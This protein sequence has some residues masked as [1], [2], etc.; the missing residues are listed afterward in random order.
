MLIASYREQHE[1]IT[2]IRFAGIFAS[3][4]TIGCLGSFYLFGFTLWF[5]DYPHGGNFGLLVA[6]PIFIS[7]DWIRHVDW[8]TFRHARTCRTYYCI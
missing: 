6:V 8:L 3:L 5:N 4:F 1:K 7:C 2:A